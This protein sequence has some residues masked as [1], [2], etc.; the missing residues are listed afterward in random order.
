MEFNGGEDHKP[1]EGCLASAVLLHDFI[2]VIR[3]P[4]FGFTSL[5]MGGR[6]GVSQSAKASPDIGSS[7][8]VT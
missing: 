5:R 3:N 2:G 6:F 7:P 8:G 1:D 4:G